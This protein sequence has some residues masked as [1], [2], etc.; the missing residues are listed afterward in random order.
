VDIPVTLRVH[1]TWFMATKSDHRRLEDDSDVGDAAA[2][3]RTP[4]V[5]APVP[6]SEPTDLISG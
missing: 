5:C 1:M 4:T 2:G 3:A 6:L